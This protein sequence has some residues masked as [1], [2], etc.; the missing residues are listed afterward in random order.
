MSREQ[1]TRNALRYNTQQIR[2]ILL[3]GSHYNE[4]QFVPVV[5]EAY[6]HAE[7]FR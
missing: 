7:P 6:G 5:K 2:P 4:T 1:R 3:R